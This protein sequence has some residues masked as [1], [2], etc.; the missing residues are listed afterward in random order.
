MLTISICLTKSQN[1]SFEILSSCSMKTVE[2]LEHNIRNNYARVNLKNSINLYCDY[3]QR[4]SQLIEKQYLK[5][6]NQEN[7]WKELLYKIVISIIK[8]LRCDFESNNS[9]DIELVI[10]FYELLIVSFVLFFF[11]KF[12][13]RS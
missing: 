1:V 5:D 7:E 6:D 2:M 13:L 4:K 8:I 3:V 11:F 9:I 10:Y 12:S